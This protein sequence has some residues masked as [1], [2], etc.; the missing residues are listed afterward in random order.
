MRNTDP[1]VHPAQ[2]NAWQSFFRI[3]KPP[4]CLLFHGIKSETRS[5]RGEGERFRPAGRTTTQ[6]GQVWG[7]KWIPPT[8]GLRRQMRK[9]QAKEW[10]NPNLRLT[11]MARDRVSKWT[12]LLRQKQL[13]ANTVLEPV[14][15]CGDDGRVE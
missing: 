7:V 1:Q 8:D 6:G 10:P 11:Q 2:V 12:K 3:I 13:H 4:Q 9:A 14:D 15:Y 5:E